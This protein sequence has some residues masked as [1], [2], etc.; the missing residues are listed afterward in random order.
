LTQ[1]GKHEDYVI[2]YLIGF[3]DDK[4]KTDIGK[5]RLLKVLITEAAH[6]IW[7]IRCE[8]AIQRGNE[9]DKRHTEAE[10]ENKWNAAINTRLKMDRLHTDKIRYGKRAIQEKIVLQTWSRVLENEGNLPDNWIQ[11]T[12]VLVG[13]VSRR[14]RGRNR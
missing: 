6:L 10:I 3:K 7:K 2:G 9:P 4:G 8:R 1:L 11:S 13:S 12:G 14:P 5:T